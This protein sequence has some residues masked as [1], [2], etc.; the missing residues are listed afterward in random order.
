MF[1][2]RIL[3]PGRKEQEVVELMERHLKILLSAFALFKTALENQDK[4]SM[5]GVADLER[6]ADEVRREIIGRIYAGAFL[7]YLRPSLCQFVEMAE[8]IFDALKETAG[9]FMDLDLPA[10]IQEETHAVSAL[11]L[12]MAEMLETTF[13][14]MLQGE[15]LREKMLAI[16]IFEK[17]IDEIKLHLGRELWDIPVASFWEGKALSDF[18][19]G[20][21]TIS[22]IMEDASDRLQIIHV[23]M[24]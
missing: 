24:R 14:A 9:R 19:T 8:H 5:I 16:R 6:E 4:G 15:D 12:Q 23:S 21:T 2:D 10:A 17:K 13:E 18:V 1:L 11:N 3:S 7:P 22:D 20:L